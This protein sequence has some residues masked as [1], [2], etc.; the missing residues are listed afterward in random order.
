MLGFLSKNKKENIY[1]K[2]NWKYADSCYQ[3]YSPKGDNY[4]VK[5]Y[6]VFTCDSCMGMQL[7]INDYVVK[8]GSYIVKCLSTARILSEEQFLNDY[9]LN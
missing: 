9:T 8:R 3:I 1:H 5:I 4:G 2:H 7:I 6:D